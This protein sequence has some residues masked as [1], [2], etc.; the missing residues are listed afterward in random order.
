MPLSTR[1]SALRA[2]GTQP[3]V[4]LRRTCF[5]GGSRPSRALQSGSCGRA[6]RTRRHAEA[7]VK[8]SKGDDKGSENPSEEAAGPSVLTQELG[9]VQSP[10]SVW[11]PQPDV[12]EKVSNQP[13]RLS[14]V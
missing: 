14:H 11:L 12:S 4:G 1:P 8:V 7:D 9:N 2:T 3:A 5:S 10:A 6:V 13:F